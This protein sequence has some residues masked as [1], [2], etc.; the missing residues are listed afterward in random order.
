MGKG[1]PRCRRWRVRELE[2]CRRIVFVDACNRLFAVW[3][4]RERGIWGAV[5]VHPV[6]KNRGKKT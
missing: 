3:A 6:P 1:I 5:A 2:G 4:A